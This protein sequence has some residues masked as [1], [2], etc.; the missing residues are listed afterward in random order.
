MTAGLVHQYINECLQP[1]LHVE[2][3]LMDEDEE[4]FKQRL[5]QRLKKSLIF[6]RGVYSVPQMGP[7]RNPYDTSKIA[8]GSSSGSASLVSAGLCPVALGVDGG[9]SVRMP[10]SLCGVVGLKPTFMLFN[11]MLFNHY[12][13]QLVV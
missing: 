4:S 6:F 2:E 12:F 3:R 13:H 7:T 1:Y 10:A 9:G 5:K 8:G 11:I